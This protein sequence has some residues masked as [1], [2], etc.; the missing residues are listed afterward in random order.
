[1]TTIINT[2]DMNSVL[3]I[4]ENIVFIADGRKEWQGDKETVITSQNQKL[5]DL[6][7]ASDLFK[8]VKDIEN[9]GTL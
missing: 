6:V 2:H 1:M 7:F 4:G 3:G 8:K 9:K 5:N